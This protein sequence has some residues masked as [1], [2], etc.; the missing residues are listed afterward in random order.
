MQLF[1]Q[2]IQDKIIVSISNIHL[3]IKLQM[4]IQILT[5]KKR[6]LKFHYKSMFIP[7]SNQNIDVFFCV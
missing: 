2:T 1:D 6:L 3:T 5:A 4:I 7:N